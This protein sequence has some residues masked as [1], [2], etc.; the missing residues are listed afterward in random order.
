MK[1]KKKM[2]YFLISFRWQKE[3]R[4]GY[5]NFWFHIDNFFSLEW[6]KNRVGFKNIIILNIYEFKKKKDFDDFE[7][8][9]LCK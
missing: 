5:G 6:I 9:Q 7:R 8:W 3:L 4:E 2:R 1:N